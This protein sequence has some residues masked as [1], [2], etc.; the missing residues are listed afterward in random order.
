[1]CHFGEGDQTEPVGSPEKWETVASGQWIQ[2]VTW[3]RIVVYY[4]TGDKTKA[5]DRKSMVD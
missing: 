2:R 4:E 5:K 1:M 3:N